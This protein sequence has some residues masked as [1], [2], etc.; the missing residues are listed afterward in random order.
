MYKKK[1]YEYE[2]QNIYVKKQS[3]RVLII[4]NI[5][6]FYS[7]NSENRKSLIIIEKSMSQIINSFSF[8]SLFKN[9]D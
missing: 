8:C 6:D 1:V 7:I 2:K 3:V 4:K 9:K 5:N